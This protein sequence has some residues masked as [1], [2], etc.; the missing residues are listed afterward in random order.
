LPV[1]KPQ[2]LLETNTLHPDLLYLQRERKTEMIKVTR[3]D[4]SE[5]FLNVE[6]IQSLQAAPDT[7]ITF[8]NNAR[9][10]VKEPVE[11]LSQQIVEYQRS[12]YT[13]R[14]NKCQPDTLIS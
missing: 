7:V 5:L 6:M 14:Y 12:I 11:K 3:F 9:I 13:K 4:N 2:W 8:S 10:M 1:E